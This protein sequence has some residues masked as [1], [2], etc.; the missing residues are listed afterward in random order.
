MKRLLKNVL[1][2]C[3]LP[4]AYHPAKPG[5]PSL[6]SLVSSSVPSPHEKEII[7]Y[8]RRGIDYSQC[9][10]GRMLYDI[11]R[12]DARV[13]INDVLAAEGLQDVDSNTLYTDG[14]WT[15]AGATIYYIKHYHLPIP[16]DFVA[17]AK[18]NNWQTVDESRVDFSKLDC[19]SFYK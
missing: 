2:V 15:W 16:A 14:E 19:F 6:K 11:L 3:D 1:D 13:R 12:T 18:N 7:E 5:K 4:P 17:Y 10:D 8:M 9:P